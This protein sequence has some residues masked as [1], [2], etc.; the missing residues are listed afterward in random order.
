MSDGKILVIVESPGKTAKI[1][2]FLGSNY[3]VKACV[4]IFRDLD[5]HPKSGSMSIDFDNNFEPQYV[6]TKPDV[7]RNLKSA[8]KSASEVYLAT[9]ND[10]E[11]HG[12][13]QALVDVLKPKKYSRIIFNEITKKA[14]LEGIKNKGKIDQ[15]NVDAQKTRRVVDRLFGYGQVTKIVNKKTGGKSTGR[16]QSS[17]LR[18]IVEKENEIVNFLK[19]NSDSSSFRISGKISGLKVGLYSLE[20]DPETENPYK[21]KITP[22]KLSNSKDQNKYANEFLN[23]CLKS[24][25]IVHSVTKKPAIRSPPAPFT[26]STLQQE[27]HRK[28]G[29]ALDL[30][31]KVAQKLYEGGYITYMRTDSIEISED[32]HKE[33]KKVIEKE[34]GEK[35]YRKT[36]FKNKNKSAQLAHECV[37]PVHPELLD[38]DDEIDDDLQIKLYKLIWRRTIASQMQPAKLDVTTIQIDISKYSGRSPFY[39][40]QS[41]IEKITFK[42]FMKVYSE[43]VDDAVEEET[44]TNFD[45]DIP[46]V[47]DKLTMEEIIAKQEYLRPPCRFSEASL[48]KKLT[49]LGIGRPSTYAQLI[50][51]LFER[52]YAETGNVPGIK[53]NI[54]ILNIGSILSPSVKPLSGLKIKEKKSDIVE[55][56]LDILLGKETKKLI[57]TELGKSVIEYM[58]ENF[59]E[60]IDYDFT[61]KLELNMD[62]VASGDKVWHKVVK[63]F[64]DKMNALVEKVGPITQS[65]YAESS[66]KLGTDS[67]GN[68]IIVT[69][70]KNGPTIIKIIDGKQ[71]Y[72]NLPNKTKL[73]KIDLETAIEIF[74]STTIILGEYKKSDVVIRKSKAGVHYISYGD[75]QYCPIPKD[76]EYNKIKLK[77]AI[78][79]IEN[80]KENMS[81]NIISEFDV[82]GGKALVLK[83]KGTFPPYI[84]FTPKNGVKTN[85]P[86]HKSIKVDTLTKKKVTEII[87]TKYKK[88]SIKK[89]IKK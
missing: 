19:N 56:K 14:I 54:I 27:A 42:G 8:Y 33:I 59:A 46:E 11:G 78:T 20:T 37:R 77:K 66:N 5:P 2:K 28:H 61:A 86:V 44:M 1:A 69:N 23:T 17:T 15:N 64:Y 47:G 18:L 53:K 13:A 81:S 7:V 34:Y 71:Y 68:D 83:G 32:G 70:T 87:S 30:T 38:L 10:I 73:E 36:T 50:K 62:K 22:I 6:I 65:I 72:A 63:R 21:G 43:S 57:P 75:K 3:I 84:Q 55:T 45:G 76:V 35:Y 4:G 31:M 39:Y 51:T 60:L 85:Y 26:T 49:E 12:M 80:Y 58:S 41:Q 79:L 88:P 67:D 52:L 16:V 74:N 9:D 82:N 89:V 24:K 40:F 29:L 25:F 48:I